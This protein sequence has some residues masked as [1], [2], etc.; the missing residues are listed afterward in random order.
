M[1]PNRIATLAAGAAVLRARLDNIGTQGFGNLDGTLRV[2]ALAEK[3]SEELE[4]AH[5][6]LSRGRAEETVMALETATHTVSRLGHEAEAVGMPESVTA[7]AE[8][9]WRQV[10]DTF[11]RLL[12]EL[13]W[14][15]PRCEPDDDDDEESW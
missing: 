8:R 11:E 7:P 2:M 15:E 9:L 5:D 10:D 12:Q 3:L 6:L 4:H 1:S 13:G 14:D